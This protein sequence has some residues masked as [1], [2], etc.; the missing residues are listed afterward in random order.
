MIHERQQISQ[1]ILAAA[2]A[3]AVAVA[4]REETDDKRA[5]LSHFEGYAVG[6]LQ[7]HFYFEK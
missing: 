2:A 6:C 5:S 7:F 4:A 3:A 1:N